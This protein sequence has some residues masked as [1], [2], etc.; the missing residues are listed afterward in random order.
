MK[1]C[2]CG[3]IIPYRVFLDGKWRVLRTRKSCL[4]CL[5]FGS[6]PYSQKSS[7]EKKRKQNAAKQQR[8][9]G[10]MLKT[11]GMGRP[12]LIRKSRKIEVVKHLGGRCMMCGHSRCVRNLAFHHISNKSFQIDERAFQFSWERLIPEIEKCVLICH[13]CHGEVHEGLHELRIL[14][15]LNAQLCTNLSSFV[16]VVHSFP[17]AV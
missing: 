14:K 15:I 12:N 5:P 11:Y 10:K 4:V 16:P 6:S 8:Y 7:K 3:A 17:V 2:I 13:N 1:H 9:Y